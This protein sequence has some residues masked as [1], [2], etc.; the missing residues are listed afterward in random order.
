[1]EGVPDVL[2]QAVEEEAQLYKNSRCPLCLKGEC[3]KM[4]NPVKTTRAEDGSIVTVTPFGDGP[5]PEGHAHCI[6]CS[7]DFN[8]RTGMIFRTEASLIHAPPAD[9]HQ[10]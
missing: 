9:P 1:M 4:I 2:S 10:E 6:H 8:P 5:L 7:T 3:V